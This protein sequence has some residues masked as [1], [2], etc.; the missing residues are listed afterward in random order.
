MRYLGLRS[1]PSPF[2]T[3]QCLCFVP[4]PDRPTSAFVAHITLS[5]METSHVRP[6]E[7]A[8][9]MWCE[10]ENTHRQPCSVQGSLGCPVLCPSIPGLPRHLRRAGLSSHKPTGLVR[11][12]L[13]FS[14]HSLPARLQHSPCLKAPGHGGCPCPPDSWPCTLEQVPL[15]NPKTT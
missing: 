7:V 3:T 5:L 13:S 4:T 6:S 15:V 12:P 1:Q 10:H 9:E 8:S 11:L 14:S 2:R